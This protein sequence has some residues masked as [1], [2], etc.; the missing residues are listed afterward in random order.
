MNLELNTSVR[1]S[2][3]HVHC[4]FDLLLEQHQLLYQEHITSVVLMYIA[5]K[6]SIDLTSRSVTDNEAYWLFMH[7]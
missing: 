7:V 2:S 5:H 6:K 1:V 4:Q 3:T